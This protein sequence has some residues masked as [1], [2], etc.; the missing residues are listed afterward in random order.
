MNFEYSKAEITV[1][2]TRLE[3]PP[4]M[5]EI[6][7]ELRV[8]SLDSNLNINLLKMDIEKCGTIFNTVQ[9]YCS[10][11]GEVKRIEE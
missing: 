6:N 10:V 3:K 7:Y 2:A 4:R 9:S 11:S 5:D 1:N 8:Y